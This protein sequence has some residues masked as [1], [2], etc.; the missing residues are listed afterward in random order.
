MMMMEVLMS[1]IFASIRMA[2]VLAGCSIE[3]GTRSISRLPALDFART[4]C[5]ILARRIR[6]GL[7][8]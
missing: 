6:A 1:P 7:A 4:L 8:G 5:N 2:G 3:Y